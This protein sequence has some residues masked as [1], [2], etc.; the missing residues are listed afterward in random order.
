MPRLWT[1]LG[2]STRVRDGCGALG[3]GLCATLS[4]HLNTVKKHALNETILASHKRAKDGNGRLHLLG[5]EQGVPESSVHFFGD[6]T[7]PPLRDTP[8]T[9]SRSWRSCSTASS[10]RRSLWMG[11]EGVEEIEINSENTVT[12]EFLKP[13]IV[14][15]DTLVSVLGLPDRLMKVA[16]AKDLGITTIP[17]YSAAF[18]F[19]AAFPPQHMTNVLAACRRHE[20]GICR[21]WVF[22]FARLPHSY[23]SR[24]HP[25]LFSSDLRY[26]L[27]PT[28]QYFYFPLHY[29]SVLTHIC[30]IYLGVLL[31]LIVRPPLAPVPPCHSTTPLSLAYLPPTFLLPS[32][33]IFICSLHPQSH[34]LLRVSVLHLLTNASLRRT[35]EIRARPLLL[36]FNG[37][38]EKQFPGEERFLTPSPKVATHDLRPEISV[39]GVADKVASIV[40][41]GEYDSVMYNFAPADMQRARQPEQVQQH[42]LTYLAAAPV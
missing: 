10:R 23:C 19:R 3:R 15:G 24:K 29:T 36:E 39:Q 40:E 12:D 16:I 32:A 14:N 30:L 26:C 38:V 27:H 11:G 37:G 31:V 4:R 42:A 2:R 18:P 41:S 21:W 6:T 35:R 9:C 20:A 8:P 1:T 13:I 17:R 34:P 5:L 28:P 25:R 7:P 33:S 22:L